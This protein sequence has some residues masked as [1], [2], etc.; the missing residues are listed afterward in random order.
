MQNPFIV[1]GKAVKDMFDSTNNV[2]FFDHRV[3]K[4]GAVIV[5]PIVAPIAFVS[6]F[7]TSKK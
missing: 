5:T 6:A 7:F 4:V 2:D 3:L 1:S